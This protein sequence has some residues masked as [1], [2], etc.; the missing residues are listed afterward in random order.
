[1][2]DDTR[3]RQLMQH[4]GTVA[5]LRTALATPEHL[6]RTMARDWAAGRDAEQRWHSCLRSLARNL[7]MTTEAMLANV[8][9]LVEVQ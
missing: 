8:L 6:A 1:M 7:G 2:S 9:E 3:P 5:S 4:A